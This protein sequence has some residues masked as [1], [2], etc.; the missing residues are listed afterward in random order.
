MIIE[1]D[2]LNLSIFLLAIV[3]LASGYTID[4]KT[5][6]TPI[7]F[8]GGLSTLNMWEVRCC[9]RHP[10]ECEEMKEI[11]SIQGKVLQ[12]LTLQILLIIIFKQLQINI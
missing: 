4:F 9:A 1:M 12:I 8:N 5:E 11:N 10:A 7:M 2:F 6:N 3:I